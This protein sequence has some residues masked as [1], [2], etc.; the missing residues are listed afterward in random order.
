MS[1][2]IEMTGQNYGLWTVLGRGLQ[3]NSGKA[4]WLCRC[5][6]GT[7]REVEGKSL[8]QGISRGCGCTRKENA[9][10]ASKASNTT[11]GMRNT[12]LYTIWHSMKGRIH[13]ATTNSYDRYGGRGIK[14]CP[15]WESDFPSFAKWAQENG[16]NDKLTLDR[17]DPDGDYCPENCR[18]ATWK[19]QARNKSKLTGGEG[20]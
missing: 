6:C 3:H 11:H 20:D 1:Q 16:Y 8:R 9:A 2:T 7:V 13:Y 10:K 15:E 17:I 5:A 4:Y 19:D 18:W 14:I 12:R